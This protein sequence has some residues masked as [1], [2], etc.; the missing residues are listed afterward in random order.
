[1]SVLD[2]HRSGGD[3][4]FYELTRLSAQSIS[5]EAELLIFPGALYLENTFADFG[6]FQPY[7]NIQGKPGPAQYFCRQLYPGQP[8]EDDR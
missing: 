5:E 7:G 6:S 2:V 8:E 3:A 4:G 1:M